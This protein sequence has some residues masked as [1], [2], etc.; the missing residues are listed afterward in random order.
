[1]EET[2]RVSMSSE[3]NRYLLYILDAQGEDEDDYCVRASTAAGTRQSRAKVTVRCMYTFS[4]Y[5][6]HCYICCVDVV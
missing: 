3:G 6:F 5:I 2:S 4:L 1:M